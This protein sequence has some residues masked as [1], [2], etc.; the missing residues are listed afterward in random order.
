MF[1]ASEETAFSAPRFAVAGALTPAPA[2]KMSLGLLLSVVLLVEGTEPAGAKGR[3]C[4]AELRGCSCA[5]AELAFMRGLAAF[6]KSRL[7]EQINGTGDPEQATCTDPR[8]AAGSFDWLAQAEACFSRAIICHPGH[9]SARYWLG[10]TYLEQGNPKDAA[11]EISKSLEAEEPPHADRWRILAHLG[12]AQLE[13][14]EEGMARG[15]LAAAHNS[16]EKDRKCSKNEPWDESD[17]KALFHLG[18]SLERLGIDQESAEVI[19]RARRLSSGAD[20]D[21]QATARPRYCGPFWPEVA[22]WRWDGWLGL[23]TGWDSNPN[24]LDDEMVLRTFDGDTV[25]GAAPD[26]VRDLDARLAFYR[27]NERNGADMAD[28]KSNGLSLGL[29]LEG[30]QSFYREFDYLDLAQSRAVVH[31]AWGKDPLSYLTG[32]LGYSRVPHG[33]GPVSVLLQIGYTFTQLDGEMYFRGAGIALSMTA[34]ETPFTDTQLE[35][36]YQDLDFEETLLEGRDRS[37]NLRAI[38]LSQFFYLKR[39]NRYL[40]LGFMAGERDADRAYARSF[41][42][43]Y[44]EA[45]LPLKPN[46]SVLL[47]G[48]VRSTDFDYPES[49]LFLPTAATDRR[50]D[51]TVAATLRLV[52]SI[53]PDLL[54]TAAWHHTDRDSKMELPPGIAGLD[55]ERT[56]GTFGFRWLF[57]SRR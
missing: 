26:D 57:G 12:A 38:D 52:W 42:Q 37:G 51:T 22:R 56:Q 40:R 4:D 16:L 36:I 9:G 55:Y 30:G 46:W 29:T 44:L 14:A 8:D 2:R 50:E 33:A 7:P 43:P 13:L 47:T 34:R 48:S 6:D 19:A 53:R 15:S 45:T 20:D 54:L 31:L 41:I 10:V 28:Q 32:A 18:R 27:L 23:S 1:Y 39:R 3:D 35:L 17:L 49:N 21:G 5:D 25:R 11:V 24:F